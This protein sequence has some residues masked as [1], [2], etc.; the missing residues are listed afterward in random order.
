MCL[1]KDR[2]ADQGQHDLVFVGCRRKEFGQ[3]NGETRIYRRGESPEAG[4]KPTGE[5][6]HPVGN[7]GP[8][9]QQDYTRRRW[10]LRSKENARRHRLQLP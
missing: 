2:K 1:T 8:H 3:R 5:R 10:P 7:C 6:F 9:L 4:R